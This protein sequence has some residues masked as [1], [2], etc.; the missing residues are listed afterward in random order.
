MSPRCAACKG[1]GGEQTGETSFSWVNCK[2]CHGTG[3][4]ADCNC[5]HID[6]DW[7]HNPSHVI[8]AQKA[9]LEEEMRGRDLAKACAEAAPVRRA[10]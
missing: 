3:I 6:C 4:K 7:L 10:S 8:D 5:G 9:A 1:E 2:A